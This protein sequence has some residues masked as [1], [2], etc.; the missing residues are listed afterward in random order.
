MAAL[1]IAAS[2]R[3]EQPNGTGFEIWYLGVFYGGSIPRLDIPA[4]RMIQTPAKHKNQ[5]F[6]AR[7]SSSA[8]PQQGTVSP[9]RNQP[10]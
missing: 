5:S 1:C 3:F 8:T 6:V 7:K 2:I 9:L 4:N 10:L